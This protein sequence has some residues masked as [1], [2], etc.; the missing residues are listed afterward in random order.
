VFAAL[1]D[2]AHLVVTFLA[3]ALGS[4]DRIAQAEPYPDLCQLTADRGFVLRACTL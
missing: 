2:V 3:W 1:A 4:V